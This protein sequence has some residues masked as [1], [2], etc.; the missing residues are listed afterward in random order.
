MKKIVAMCLI[1]SLVVSINSV[2]VYAQSVGN[3]TQTENT[4]EQSADTQE[5]NDVVDEDMYPA[6]WDPDDPQI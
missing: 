1:A 3:N 5:L 6:D 4:V 2:P